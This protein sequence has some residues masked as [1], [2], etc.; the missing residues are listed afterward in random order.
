MEQKMKREEGRRNSEGSLIA[1]TPAMIS[2]TDS[3]KASLDEWVCQLA[4]NRQ[5]I[6]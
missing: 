1:D 6:L 3:D 2:D 5:D 4:K